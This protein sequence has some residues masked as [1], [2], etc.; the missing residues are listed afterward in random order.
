MI[1]AYCKLKWKKV[2]AR[3]KKSIPRQK[4]NNVNKMVKIKACKIHEW[5]VSS[6]T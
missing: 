1:P 4:V 2:S 5:V 3:A 6:N